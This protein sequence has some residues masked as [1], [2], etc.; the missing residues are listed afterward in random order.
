MKINDL[1]IDDL[2]ITDVRVT[3]S[4]FAKYALLLVLAL[5]C[6]PAVWAGIYQQ[7][8]VVRMRM[9]DCLPVHHAFMVA[10]A[11]QPTQ[12]GGE[13]C[14][15]YTLISDKVVFVIVGS[16]SDQLVPLADVVDFRFHKNELAMRIDDARHES[17]FSIKEMILRSEWDMVQKHIS[18][19]LN[20]PSSPATARMAMRTGD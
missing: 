13:V 4:K 14:P 17:K 2:K 20:D 16:S 3:D 6:C 12:M 5:S 11:G 19:E 8:T 7:G 9:G 10:M 15:E 18:A 1:K